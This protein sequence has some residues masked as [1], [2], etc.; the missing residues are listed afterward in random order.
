MR[1]ARLFI[2]I[3][4]LV[5]SLPAQGVSNQESYW[6]YTYSS[7]MK[8]V[9]I[10]GLENDQLLI[11]NGSWDVKVS[12]DEIEMILMPPGPSV[13]GQILGGFFCGYGGLIGGCLTGVMMFPGSFNND[14][15]TL[16]GL[17]MLAGAAAGIYYGRKLGGGFLKGQ[18]E[19]LADMSMWTLDE[20][21]EWIQTN[22][23]Y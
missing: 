6:I 5:G 15:G 17:F 22:L 2:F 20:K 16:P 12:L 14:E 18:P 19:V 1:T 7:E 23:I 3:F 11:N 4:L 21:K 13:L 8:D 9:A 10:V